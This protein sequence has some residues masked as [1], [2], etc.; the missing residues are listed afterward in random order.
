MQRK[1]ARSFH[2]K[3]A[4]KLC[5]EYV[6]DCLVAKF[7]AVGMT[8]TQVKLHQLDDVSNAI[9][10]VVMKQFFFRHNKNSC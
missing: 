7:S 5:R 6:M 4:S 8:K 1:F 10:A 9:T 2:K 3:H